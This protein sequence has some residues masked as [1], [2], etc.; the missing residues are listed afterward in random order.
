M[1]AKRV[2]DLGGISYKFMP[3]VAGSPDRVCLLP[4][5]VV[6]FVELKAVG[7][8]L[9][10]VQKLWHER[11]AALGVVVDVITGADAARAWTP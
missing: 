5:G 2:R 10:P 6:K 11:A 1:F 9:R 7:G 3:I 4:G 8:Q